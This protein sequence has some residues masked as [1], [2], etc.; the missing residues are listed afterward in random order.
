M[1]LILM[2]DQFRNMQTRS[3]IHPVHDNSHVKLDTQKGFFLPLV[4][5][6]AF[7]QPDDISFIFKLL[8][9]N[10]F[11]DCF[12]KL[13]KNICSQMEFFFLMVKL[14]PGTHSIL[15]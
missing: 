2:Y 4:I 7:H 14:S 15:V 1:A 10:A 9:E 8:S 5:F 3:N 13:I 6:P 11:F 12:P